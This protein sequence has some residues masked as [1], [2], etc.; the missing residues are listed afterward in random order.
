LL[1]GLQVLPERHGSQELTEKSPVCDCPTYRFNIIRICKTCRADWLSA[2]QNWF[3][4]RS[5]A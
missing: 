2:M 3:R 1:K 5:P 4:A